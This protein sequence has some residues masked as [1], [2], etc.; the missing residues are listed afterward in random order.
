MPKKSVNELLALLQESVLFARGIRITERDMLAALLDNVVSI[1]VAHD[2]AAKS[3]EYPEKQDLVKSI[4]CL[5][6][7]IA[8]LVNNM[9]EAEVTG[10]PPRSEPESSDRRT[11]PA[12]TLG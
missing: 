1:D 11:P 8:V 3:R 6:H 12:A 10:R 9:D 2:I 4:E 5:V 7:V